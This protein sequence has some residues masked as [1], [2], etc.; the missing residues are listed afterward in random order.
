MNLAE[1]NQSDGYNPFVYIHPERDGYEERVLSLI[2]TIIINTDGGEKKGGSDPFWDKAERLFLQAVFFFTAV[3]FTPEERNMNTVLKLITML[4]IGEEQ[5]DMNS[6]L[7]IY[8]NIFA[9]RF[10]EEHIGVQQ[11]REFRS[12]ASG[13]T[14]K[15][16]VISAVARLAPFRTS[17]VQKIFS[18]DSML[19]DRVGEEKTAIFVVVPP[20]DPTFNFIAGMLFTQLFQELEYCATQEHKHD[21]QRLPVPCR[22]ILDEFANTCTI[23][24]FVKILA[25]ARSFGIGIV[26]ILQSLEQIKNMYK[27]EWGVIVDNC[28]TLLYLGSITHM[29]TLEYMSKLLG[30]GTFDKRSTGRTK[31]K[32]GSSSQNFDVVGRELMFPDEIRK[33][34]KKDCLFIVGGRN[35][36][37]SEKYEYKN[38]PNYRFTSDANPEFSYHYT[39]E[40]PPELKKRRVSSGSEP[41]HGEEVPAI[42]SN[43]AAKVEV[44]AIKIESDSKKILS[45][46]TQNVNN[47]Q[48]IPD[49][50]MIVDD[51]ENTAEEVGRKMLQELVGKEEAAREDAKLSVIEETQAFLENMREQK[52][53][54]EENLIH[55]VNRLGRTFRNLDFIPDELIIVDDGE[56]TKTLDEK[57]VEYILNEEDMASPEELRD[58]ME[59]VDSLLAELATDFDELDL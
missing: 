57:A 37:Y 3:G 1:K 11:Y 17:A 56:G 26:P 6:D 33:L 41:A 53:R 13:K 24:N 8:V 4:K 55:T 20:T 48:I 49:E 40:Q 10:G 39:P 25:Y 38:H 45:Y 9:S 43:E 15:S 58:I 28:N 23:P 50:L 27:D 44:E 19:L 29:D 52:I 32:Q 31:G 36:F 51:G 59:D 42:I 12:K 30:K 18:Y 46:M 34:H 5:D 54:I 21:G 22:F 35:P 16:I 14:A 7:D 2:E 47:L